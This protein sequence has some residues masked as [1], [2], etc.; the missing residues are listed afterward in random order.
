MKAYL[1]VRLLVIT[2]GILPI[3]TGISLGIINRIY[4]Y[5]E[6]VS[7]GYYFQ[8]GWVATLLAYGWPFLFL[9]LLPYSGLY[10]LERVGAFPLWKKWLI[11]YGLMVA[12]GLLLP[13]FSLGM[14]FGAKAYPR[15]FILYALLTL[16][17]C[18]VCN[19]CLNKVMPAPARE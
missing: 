8:L 16:V 12:M 19:Y 3:C 6:P 5:E 1:A 7:F 18:P 11:C 10:V 2:I 13:D 9:V 4:F 15:I 14:L 17:V